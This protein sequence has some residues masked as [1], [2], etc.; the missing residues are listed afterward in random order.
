MWFR[1]RRPISRPSYFEIAITTARH[2]RGRWEGQFPTVYMDDAQV[3]R[4]TADMEYVMRMADIGGC[5][6]EGIVSSAECVVKTYEHRRWGG[7][8]R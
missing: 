6:T 8:L 2:R 7:C 1:K 5:N 3:E 4:M